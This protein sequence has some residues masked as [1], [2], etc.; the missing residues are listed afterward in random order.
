MKLSGEVATYPLDLT[1]IFIPGFGAS[2]QLTELQSWFWKMKHRSLKQPVFQVEFLP[3]GKDPFEIKSRT[4]T[5]HC[6]HSV[7]MGIESSD[8]VLVF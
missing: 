2:N 8:S 7:Q 1:P 6:D 3:P 4:I 5:K